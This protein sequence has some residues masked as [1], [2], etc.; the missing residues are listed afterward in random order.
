MGSNFIR[1]IHPASSGHHRWILI[2][3][4]Y[5][6]KWIEAIPT[7]NSSHKV[8]IGFLEDIVARFG[9]PNRIV[10]DNASAF[11]DKP[12]INFCE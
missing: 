7:I 2:A 3:T 1:E 10:T 4:Y 12:F 5:F 11:K 9:C 8:I 6:T